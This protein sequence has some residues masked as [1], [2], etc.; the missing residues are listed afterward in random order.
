MKLM[1]NILFL[2]VVPISVHAISGKAFLKKVRA[3]YDN[4]ESMQL[5]THYMLYKGHYSD[6]IQTEYNGMYFKQNHDYYRK[7]QNTEIINSVSNH[8]YIKINHDQKAILISDP[9]NYSAVDFD[10]KKTFKQCKDILVKEKGNNNVITL[11]IKNKTDIPYSK[12]EIEINKN[13]YIKEIAL[14]YSIKMNFS[15]SVFKQDYRFPKLVIKYNDFKKKWK[16]K[17]GLLNTENYIS[18]LA[19]SSQIV[20][21]NNLANYQLIDVRGREF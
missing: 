7:I 11:L 2:L 9:V 10:I 1:F 16:D 18:F 20:G 14:F 13:Y 19:D 4:I 5:Y 12:I 17:S 15:S 3:Q 21:I 8:I 6:S